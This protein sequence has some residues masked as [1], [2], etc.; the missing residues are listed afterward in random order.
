M[1]CPVSYAQDHIGVFRRGLIGGYKSLIDGVEF[2]WATATTE[3][4][5]SAKSA[6]YQSCLAHVVNLINSQ[7]S[8]NVILSKT[9]K[10]RQAQFAAAQ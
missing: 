6:E 2:P 3:P 1:L 7:D 5:R 8:N 9:L 4:S 10:Q